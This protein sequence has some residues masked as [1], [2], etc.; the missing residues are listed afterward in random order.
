MWPVNDLALAGRLLRLWR[1]VATNRVVEMFGAVH[2]YEWWQPVC[3]GNF[4]SR[5]VSE[6]PALPE[7]LFWY[8]FDGDAESPVASGCNGNQIFFAVTGVHVANDVVDA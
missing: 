1:A 5:A 7:P 8:L 3:I 6:A 2:G 4:P